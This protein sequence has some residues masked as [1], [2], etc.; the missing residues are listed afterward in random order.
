M[1]TLKRTPIAFYR[2]ISHEPYIV[3]NYMRP[4]ALHASSKPEV[5]HTEQ[6][7]EFEKRKE[8]A[9]IE[10][11]EKLKMKMFSLCNAQSLGSS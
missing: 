1:D 5:I 10:K 11:G 6:D 2:K 3:N 8:I 4:N 7:S 9:L